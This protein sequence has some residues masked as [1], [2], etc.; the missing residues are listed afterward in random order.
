MIDEIE[1]FNKTFYKIFD[2]LREASGCFSGCDAA[3]KSFSEKLLK[4]YEFEYELLDLKCRIEKERELYRL[5]LQHDGLVP[6]HWRTRFLHR[7]KQNEAATLID[8]EEYEKIEEFFDECKKANAERAAAKLAA[9]Q[10]EIEAGVEWEIAEGEPT[11]AEQPHGGDEERG[12]V[13]D[14]NAK[15][16]AS[17]P[18]CGDLKQDPPDAKSPRKDKKK[19]KKAEKGEKKNVREGD[20][21]GSDGRA[22]P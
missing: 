11:A 7:K 6:Q 22:A 14:P 9:K 19:R 2:D 15:A 12:A 21:A 13:S 4:Q 20:Q 17:S 8:I 16:A 10:A 3:F 18:P 5:R 1:K